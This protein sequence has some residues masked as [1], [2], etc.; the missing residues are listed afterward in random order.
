M[1]SS[2]V[3]FLKLYF[4]L[5]VSSSETIPIPA[6][7]LYCLPACRPLGLPHSGSKPKHHAYTQASAAPLWSPSKSS[8]LTS[9]LTLALFSASLHIWIV[10][11]IYK[12]KHQQKQLFFFL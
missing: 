6:T 12:H 10:M 8:D 3:F 7:H 5:S 1:S 4:I 2:I 11:S 9:F